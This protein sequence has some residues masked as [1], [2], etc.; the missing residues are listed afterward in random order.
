MPVANSTI[1]IPR[2]TSPCASVNTLPC[3]AV[4]IAANSSRLA[5]RSSRYLNMIRA[6]RN[7]DVWLHVSKAFWATATAA[8][9]SLRLA[10]ATRLAT[11]PVEGLNTSAKRPSFGLTTLPPTK[12]PISSFDSKACGALII[13]CLNNFYT[14][15]RFNKLAFQRNR[16][17]LWSRLSYI[18][19]FIAFN[20]FTLFRVQGH[21]NESSLF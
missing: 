1:S 11:A 10:K 9:T 16:T 13:F 17:S 20:T 21:S 5:L 15:F 19:H 8:S 7:G 18:I 12:W 14:S 2:V 6:R 4:I 3:S